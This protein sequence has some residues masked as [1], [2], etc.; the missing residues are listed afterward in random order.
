L[1]TE[2]RIKFGNKIERGKEKKKEVSYYLHLKRRL[3]IKK[4]TVTTVR[5][6]MHAITVRP[7]TG[8]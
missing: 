3:D 5:V 1:E 4:P 6:P 7:E 2:I 8:P